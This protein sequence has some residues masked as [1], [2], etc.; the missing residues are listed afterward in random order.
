VLGTTSLNALIRAAIFAR[1]S[2][3]IRFV[4]GSARSIVLSARTDTS[5]PS[6]PCRQAD[7]RMARAVSVGRAVE[8]D[9]RS[10]RQNGTRG[11]LAQPHSWDLST[12]N[13]QPGEGPE[14]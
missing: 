4:S 10:M 2:T 3:S 13:S 1:T 9:P 5:V 14:V 7:R 12:S 11:G 8:Q 6:G